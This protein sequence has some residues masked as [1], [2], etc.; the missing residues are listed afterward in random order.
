[1]S[2][3]EDEKRL[4]DAIN[5]GWGWSGVVIATVHAVSPMG[6]MLL[7]DEMERYFYLD[8]DGMQL[9]PLGDKASAEAA[10]AD[11]ETLELWGGGELVRSARERLGAPAAGHVFTLAPMH[12]IDGDYSA[13]HMVVLPLTEVAFLS[14]DLAKQ[15]RDLP[16]EA[17]V[18]IEV[19]D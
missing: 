1:M 18:K 15:L 19:I 5:A 4:L 8:T 13:E 16:D 9:S 7:S 12:W 11:P 3:I 17:Q 14:G 10:M 6:H 2:A